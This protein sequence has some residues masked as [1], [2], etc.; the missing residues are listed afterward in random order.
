M[1]NGHFP[2]CAYF[3][4]CSLNYMAY[5]L[6]L[7][8]SL[9][10]AD[11]DASEHFFLI[12]V[13][14]PNG[15]DV[16]SELPFPVIL[17][18][19]LGVETFWDMAVR[20]TVMEMNTAV[21]PAAF[22]FLLENYDYQSAI[23]LDP[24]IYVVKPL[25]H[26]LE[27]LE[28]GNDIVLTPHALAPLN[29]GKDPDDQRLMMTGVYN[30]GFLACANSSSALTLLN[31]WDEHMT[32][33]CRVDL[34]NG[35]FVDQKFMDLAP[36]YV[37][38]A[39][40]LRHPGYNVA[41]W[42]LLNRRVE[43][44][45]DG[46]R[47]NG[48]PLHFFHFSG[49]VPGDPR[50]F[51]KHQDRFTPD[52]I[53]DVKRAFQTY[54]SELDANQ[55]NSWKANRYAY[56]FFAS[57]EPIP[58]L[59]RELYAHHMQPSSAPRDEIFE[60][61]EDVLNA[62]SDDTLQMGTITITRA[63]YAI[64]QRRPDLQA[65]FPLTT[66]A[67]RISFAR[68]YIA[69]AEGEYDLPKA[70]IE[71]TEQE[72]GTTNGKNQQIGQGFRL[73][74]AK[75]WAAQK[76]VALAPRF[77]S[78][79]RLLPNN[80]RVSIRNK[81]LDRAAQPSFAGQIA[82]RSR[83][84]FDP[85]LQSG[86]DIWGFF[87]QISGVG[88]GARRMSVA[89]SVVDLPVTNNNIHQRQFNRAEQPDHRISIFHVNADQTQMYL[90]R[91]GRKRLKGQYR[92]GYWAWELETLPAEWNGAFDY[93]DEIWTPSTFVQAAVQKST[94]LPVYVIPHSVPS[95]ETTNSDRALLGLPL[96]E[97]LF[98][99]TYDRNSFVSRKN[100]R[101]AYEAFCQAFPRANA[102]GPK[103]VVKAHGKTA[104][105]QASSD[106]L[107]EIGNDERVII[108]DEAMSE[109][110][111]S[112]LQKS[113]D[114]LISL[115]R[116]EG[117]GLNILEFMAL[118]KPVIATNYGGNRDFLDKET[119][120]PVDYKR[121]AIQPGEYPHGVGQSWAEPDYEDAAMALRNVYSQSDEVAEVASNAKARAL[122]A[123]SSAI[124]GQLIKERIAQI[125]REYFA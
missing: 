67:G 95:I 52:T 55:H 30:L 78:V 47:V 88:E 63:M 19:N 93:L 24:D 80:I 121:S 43:Q 16:L 104:S 103:L 91:I 4:I 5:A 114:A 107:D 105:H 108:I 22:K 12:L 49:V 57:G 6:T 23:Y 9:Q 45:D 53:G 13:D 35:L 64:W 65:A 26:V 36:A 86:A 83:K 111:Y 100:P 8:Q 118:G 124:V 106:I 25:S 20:Y 90:D 97:F 70:A 96:N 46:W 34:A 7:F 56:N 29:D 41:Y 79:Y 11:P 99:L 66:D 87:D 125:E 102:G 77:R 115:H 44:T 1:T 61:N 17:A 89:S 84:R 69:S 112:A 32:A 110:Q 101:G 116:S 68:W 122:S 72:L 75:T 58:S 50:V 76:A 59:Y 38:R 33:D 113:C 119:G 48:K 21:K 37:E 94:E 14:E 73:A 74:G 120:F 2:S 98:F 82:D 31:W 10:E 15:D 40:I 62:R 117:F 39:K 18:K 85:S 71:K 28:S 81:L 92:I 60:F 3:S 51:S 27:A 123:Y 109:V 54:L 42:N